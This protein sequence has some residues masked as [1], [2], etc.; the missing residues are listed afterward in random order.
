MEK[1]IIQF[2]EAKNTQQL[3]LVLSHYFAR[4]DIKSMA[5]T[6]YQ[7]HT[8]TGNKLVYDWVSPPLKAWHCYYLEQNYADNDR[9][10]ET[11]EHSMM[12]VFWDVML[13]LANAKNRKEKRIREESIAFGID[14][15]LSIPIHDPKG[16]LINV[17]L[18]QRL[19]EKGLVDW[20]EKQCLWVGI[21]QVYCHYL[22]KLL[23]TKQVNQT[24][25]TQR[26]KECLAL[27]A[28]GVRT[29]A[30]A[31][32][33]AISERTVN[34]HLQNANRKLGVNNKYLAILAWKN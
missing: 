20:Q 18:H 22:R 30:I 13:Q 31:N 1:L 9:T 2:Q 10:L 21:V 19:N 4:Q 28:Q 17:V 16:D 25:L 33:L 32:Q 14:K 26:E 7:Q 29:A 15:G 23:T 8:K 34:F 3:S 24:Y 5:V 12:P 27:T 6:Y 11:T